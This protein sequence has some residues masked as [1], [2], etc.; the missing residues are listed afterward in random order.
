MIKLSLRW[1][2]PFVETP[3]PGGVMFTMF[4]PFVWTLE[5]PPVGLFPSSGSV[6]AWS[7]WCLGP[8][9]N[10]GGG[11]S[12]WPTYKAVCSKQTS[13]KVSKVEGNVYFAWG[14]A[15]E[16]GGAF[17][18]WRIAKGR[19]ALWTG[20]VA[21]RSI[22]TSDIRREPWGFYGPCQVSITSE[23]W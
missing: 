2:L 12:R 9:W 19:K 16:E 22:V 13:A 5:N 11:P 23:V 8:C 3:G 10:C 20:V 15:L 1:F 18:Q 17:K 7:C 6:P 14:S 21:V 4:L